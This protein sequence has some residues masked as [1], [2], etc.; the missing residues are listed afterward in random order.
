VKLVKRPSFYE[1]PNKSSVPDRSLALLHGADCLV[2]S[3]L[4]TCA[5]WTGPRPLPLLLLRY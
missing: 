3:L 5:H 1:C 4:Q 2:T